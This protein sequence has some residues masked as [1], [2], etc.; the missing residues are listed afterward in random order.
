MG[1]NNKKKN[2]ILEEANI[3]LSCCYV[4]FFLIKGNAST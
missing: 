1:Y 3:P 4:H 2:Y